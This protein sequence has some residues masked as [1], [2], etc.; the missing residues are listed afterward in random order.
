GTRE[1]CRDFHATGEPIPVQLG[2]SAGQN[3]IVG[4]FVIVNRRTFADGTIFRG[5]S[6][7]LPKVCLE[8]GQGVLGRSAVHV[9]EARASGHFV[10]SRFHLPV[11]ARASTRSAWSLSHSW[12]SE[13]GHRS[14]APHSTL[15]QPA[16][17]PRSA[18]DARRCFAQGHQRCAWASGCEHERALPAFGC[19]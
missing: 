19:R 10:A 18:F 3:H 17:C 8:T 13:S 14:F 4:A 2:F 11:R 5:V 15:P 6:M 9:F 7:T 16:I 12:P 1:S